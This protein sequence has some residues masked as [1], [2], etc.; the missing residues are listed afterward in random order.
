MP[1]NSTLAT[2]LALALGAAFSQPAYAQDDRGGYFGGMLGTFDYEESGPEEL[3]ISDDTTAYE[4]LGGYRFNRH[5]AVE[6]GLGRTGDIEDTFVEV[7]P[8]LG[9]VTLEAELMLDIYT[10]R[11]L[12]MLPLDQFNLFAGVG[13]FSASYGGPV[14][15]PGIGTIGEFDQ[16]ERGSHAV[17]GIQ[18]DFR[19]DLRNLSIRGQYEWFDI[20]SDVDTSG[21]SVGL[22]MRF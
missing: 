20:G 18:R 5:F 22:I 14:D 12:G 6:F 2:T 13:Y 17:L 7:L 3:T 16:H 11:A 10:L 4:L 9:A 21:L 15:F 8:P 19:L 1:P